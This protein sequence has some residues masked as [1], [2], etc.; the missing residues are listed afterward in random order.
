LQRF[1][2]RP[3]IVGPAEAHDD[4][5]DPQLLQFA[6]PGRAVGLEGDDVDLERLLRGAVLAAELGQPGQQDRQIIGVAPPCNQPSPDTAA[7]RK[8]A[9]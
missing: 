1:G 8:A 5:G 3:G 6:D 9:S 7:R 4:I 2:V